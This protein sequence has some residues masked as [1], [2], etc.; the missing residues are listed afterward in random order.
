[1]AKHIRS[2]I[3]WVLCS[4]L[5]VLWVG[6]CAWQRYNINRHRKKAESNERRKHGAGAQNKRV[7]DKGTE[8]DPRFRDGI[9]KGVE[10]T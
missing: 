4:L 3:S 5:A 2:S 6:L 9:E 10:T 7:T 1:M 8:T